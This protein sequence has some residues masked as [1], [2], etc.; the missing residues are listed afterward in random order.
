[1]SCTGNCGACTPPGYPRHMSQP[2]GQEATLYGDVWVKPW[3]MPAAGMFVPQHAHTYPHV[4][5]IAAGSVRVWQ[6]GH[7]MG[8]T[9]APGVVRIPARVKHE[10]EVLED[11]TTIFCVH[12]AAHGEAADIHEE[13]NLAR[14]I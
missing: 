1:M 14:E 5:V 10:F 3:V 11:G 2:E 13:N 6:G 8:V 7:D 9:K 4:S 12:N